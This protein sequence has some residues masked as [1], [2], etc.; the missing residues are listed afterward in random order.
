MNNNSEQSGKLYRNTVK[1]VVNR[2]KLYIIIQLNK[3]N[4][5]KRLKLSI[6]IGIILILYR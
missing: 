5:L 4:S 6:F 1:L 2:N 3:E